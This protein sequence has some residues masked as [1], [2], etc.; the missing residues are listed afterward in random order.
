[1][2][3]TI[4]SVGTIDWFQEQSE[5]LLLQLPSSLAW[6]WPAY[7]V[8]YPYIH[9]GFTCNKMCIPSFAKGTWSNNCKSRGPI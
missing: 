7:K 8:K 1:M 3:M 6:Y 5:I 4:F 9:S 2:L